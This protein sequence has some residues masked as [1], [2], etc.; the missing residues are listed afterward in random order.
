MTN[1]LITST[2]FQITKVKKQEKKQEKPTFPYSNQSKKESFYL[3]KKRL[4]KN[5]PFS[6][7]KWNENEHFLFLKT[8]FKYGSNWKDVKGS[9]FNRT[10]SQIK[11]HSQKFFFKLSKLNSLKFI[12]DKVSIEN[13]KDVVK[14]LSLDE[15]DAVFEILLNLPFFK[16]DSE[17][18]F[19]L[20][21]RLFNIRM[22]GKFNKTI[23]SDDYIV[24]YLTDNSTG[25]YLKDTKD[26]TVH[27]DKSE[28]DDDFEFFNRQIHNFNTD[29]SLNFI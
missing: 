21:Q 26:D 2:T 4:L 1:F 13:I 8:I 7:G 14:V 23:Y 5:H 11:S 29:T 27:V 25:I 9:I 18:I 3:K 10:L 20:E 24:N 22:N 28:D 12:S 17:M 6:E 16:L 19:D 15:Y